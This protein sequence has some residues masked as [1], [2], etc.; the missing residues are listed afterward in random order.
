FDQPFYLA[1]FNDSFD[2]LPR[3]EPQ[4]CCRHDAEESITADGVTEELRLVLAATPDELSICG[5]D[6]ERLWVADERGRRETASVDVRAYR[7]SDRQPVGTG[8]LLPYPPP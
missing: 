7:A 8:L 3:S 4:G 6:L 1:Q 5:D 2:L